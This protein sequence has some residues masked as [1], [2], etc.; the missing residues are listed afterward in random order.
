MTANIKGTARVNNGVRPH[1]FKAI[2]LIPAMLTILNRITALYVLLA[3]MAGP[4]PLF[5][6][7]SVC[8]LH[9]H[10][11]SQGNSSHPH[12]CCS[13]STVSTT[14]LGGTCPAENGSTEEGSEG[15]S[16]CRAIY[17]V[18]GLDLHNCVICY[19]LAQSPNGQH[20]NLTLSFV[21]NQDLQ[22]QPEVL[23]TPPSAYRLP[24]SRGPPYSV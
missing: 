13:G 1:S 7:R 8:H 24:P 23:C 14:S 9:V 17:Q 2:S 15:V 16:P 6:H 10:P 20:S 5:L 19:Q 4:L 12:H 3:L 21:C 11:V 22:F 18:D